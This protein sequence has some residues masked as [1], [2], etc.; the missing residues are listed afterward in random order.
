ME[1]PDIDLRIATLGE[2]RIPSPMQV[3][4]FMP[5]SERRLYHSDLATIRAYLEAG[6]EPPSFEV[7]GPR[8][9]IFFNPAGLRCGIV[10]CGGLCPGLNDVIRAIVISLY[11]HYGVKTVYGFR[12]GYEGLVAKHGHKP[13]E[14]TLELVNQIHQTGGTVLGSS[15]GAQDV[16]EI[17]DTLERMQISI[18]FTIG[19]DGTLRGAHQI[20]EEVAR[21]GRALSVIGIPK[22]IDNDISYVQSSFGFETAVEEARRA[23][24]A[25]HSEATG[26]RNGIGLVKLMGRESGFIA[27]HAALAD[28]QVN[29]CL[30]PEVPFTL[31]GFL[32]ALQTRLEKRAHA[33]IV[34]GEGAGQD[35][36]QASL[37]RDASGNIR[38]GDIGAF[39]RDRIK[40][41]FQRVGM[42][43][44]LKYIDPSYS[45]RSQ[46]ANARDAAL[47]W[48]LGQ[49]AVHAGMSGRTDM[50]MGTW[51]DTPTH[52]PIRLAISARKKID[53][54]GW[55]WNAVLASTGQPREM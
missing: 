17:V 38:F 33:V 51:E 53:P 35:L 48:L 30:V 27:A 31:E 32:K 39:L 21:R 10:T 43:I 54:E 4:R 18:L 29:F 3:Q 11:H 25:A 16:R 13:V 14:L 12:Y 34:V 47:C 23:T 49:S 1:L 52:V 5:T 8:E 19:G 22:T 26:A 45:I 24:Y 46:P 2:C 9:K 55:F 15:R 44:S 36:L 42:E 7:A 28:T 41:H 40:E 50:V 37:G 6:R 20:A